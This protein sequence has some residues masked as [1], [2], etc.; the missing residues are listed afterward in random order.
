M[1]T[2]PRTFRYLPVDIYTSGYR[3][4]GKIMAAN[5]GI[6]GVMNDPTHSA[7]EVYD[8]RLAKI[9]MPTK[10]V[11]H[12]DQV[13]MVKKRIVVL[14]LSRREDLGPAALVRAG[15][16]TINTYPTRVTTQNYE[17]EGSLELPGRF[18]FQGL[19]FDGTR[20]FIP[21][22]D[23]VLTAILIPNLRV[24]SPALL[25][26]RSHVDIL[27]LLTQRAKDEK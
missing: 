26:N 1:N 10:L 11:D 23:A 8:A 16:G 13:R 21:M 22:F 6:I 27:A 4:V 14:C 15:Y 19:M 18:D 12:F 17:T 7:L 2:S 25:V 20:E 5:S 3:V 9:H 24:E